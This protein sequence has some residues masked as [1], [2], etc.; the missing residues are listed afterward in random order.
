[1]VETRTRAETIELLRRWIRA[2]HPTPP[3]EFAD[4]VDLIE[5]R[6]LSSL[7]LVEFLLYIEELS[8]R[9]VLSED[10]R[11]DQMR[12]LARIYASFFQEAAR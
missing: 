12:T 6:L 3:E 9:P 1:M 2:A 8:G 11:P 10:L 5:S 4:D 7:Q